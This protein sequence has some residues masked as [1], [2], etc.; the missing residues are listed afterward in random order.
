MSKKGQVEPVK[1]RSQK[2]GK[3]SVESVDVLEEES[4]VLKNKTKEASKLNPASK[5]IQK[6][7]VEVNRDNKEKSEVKQQKKQENSGKKTRKASKDQTK[8]AEEE[9]D[10]LDI[11]NFASF[12]K[13][14]AE[15]YARLR[16]KTITKIQLDKHQIKNAVQ[17]L[18][19]FH[20]N[21]KKKNQLLDNDEDFIYLEI[22]LSEVPARYSIRPVQIKLPEPIYGPQFQ[23]RFCVFSTD[24]QRAYKDKIQDLDV[25]SIAK[26]IGYTKLVKNHPQYGDKRK[27][28]YDF[29]LFFCDYKLYNLLRKPTGKIF[30][31]RKKIPF[32]I[33]CE[34]VPEHQK[35]E[36]K[37]YE[38]Y[39]NGLSSCTYF[40]MG[41]GPVYTVKVARV[42]MGLK[43][44]VKNIIH[45][46]YN[47][48]P[49]ILKDSI[50]HTKVRQVSIK[51][52]ESISLPIFNQ[53]SSE[54]L[55][56]F[57]GKEIKAKENEIDQEEDDDIDA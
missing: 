37:S 51:T 4:P 3:Q 29:D 26:V 43:E 18:I 56:A 46:V 15:K 53:L 48:I 19:T 38:D 25:P 34:K 2:K 12:S 21:N 14:Q 44:T 33:D 27:L 35:D 17:A 11:K 57:L 9:P 28:F 30:Y 8:T 50:D 49:H 23:S 36:Y 39:L 45:G 7:A 40:S 5:K 22:V 6:Q 10:V 41:N 54:E 55:S 13:E 52:S 1:T 16:R 31:E 32:P 42:A 47:T 24:P 20:N